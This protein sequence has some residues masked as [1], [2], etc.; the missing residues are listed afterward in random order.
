M[1]KSSCRKYFATVF[2]GDFATFIASGLHS[3]QVE[4]FITF[5]NEELTCS[6]ALGGTNFNHKSLQ[7]LLFASHYVPHPQPQMD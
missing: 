7:G 1:L 4:R 2:K 6:A 3:L 5:L